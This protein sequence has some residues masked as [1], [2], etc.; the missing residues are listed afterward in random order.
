MGSCFLFYME[1][2]R[3]HSPLFTLDDMYIHMYLDTFYHY[4]GLYP[5]IK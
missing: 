2:K 4:N 5:D 1:V 3:L